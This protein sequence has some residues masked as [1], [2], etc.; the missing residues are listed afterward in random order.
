MPDLPGILGPWWLRRRTNADQD[1][2]RGMEC[3]DGLEKGILVQQIDII[4]LRFDCSSCESHDEL[5]NLQASGPQN[6]WKSFE[7]S[8]ENPKS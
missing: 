8:R 6:V 7:K 4:Y 5:R 1:K 3:A 2:T